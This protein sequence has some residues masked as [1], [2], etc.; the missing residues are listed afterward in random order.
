[1][2]YILLIMVLFSQLDCNSSA[3]QIKPERKPFQKSGIELKSPDNYRLREKKDGSEYDP[4]PKIVL[5]DQTVG[6]YE[7]RWIGYD[8]EEKVVKF[9]RADAIDAV[10]EAKAEKQSDGKY[11]YKYIL[12]NLASSPT[13]LSGFIVQTLAADIETKKKE[14]LHIGKM[15]KNIDEFNVGTWFD[16]APLNKTTPKVEAGKS[17]EFTLSS[18]AL[19]GIVGSR[20]TAGEITLKGVGEH[21][22]QELENVLPGY[23]GLARSYTIGPDQSLAKMS[24][25]EKI[26]YLLTNLNKFYEAGWISIENTGKYKSI[27]KY[28]NLINAFREAENDFA[29][30]YVTSEFFYIIEGLSQEIAD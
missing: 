15:A 11:I 1:M 27:L 26:E 10:V 6:K 17:I 30:G 18:K 29:K 13:Y 24:E 9:Q 25:A 3:A 4:K 21:M 5:I 2:K 16:F 7:L 28:E 14:D 8:G 20:V 22:P 19:P 12:R 23:E